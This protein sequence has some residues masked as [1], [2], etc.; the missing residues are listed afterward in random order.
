MQT[1]K[2]TQEKKTKP[3]TSIQPATMVQ[4]QNH[5]PGDRK[6]LQ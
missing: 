5:T 4:R 1:N 3:Q 6:Y 2:I